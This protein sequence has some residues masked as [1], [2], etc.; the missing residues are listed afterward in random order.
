[1]APGKHAPAWPNMSQQLPNIVHFMAK[2]QR[3]QNLKPETSQTSHCC[4]TALPNGLW[5]AHRPPRH[6]RVRLPH[7]DTRTDI[8]QKVI[9]CGSVM[10]STGKRPQTKSKPNSRGRLCASLRS[11]NAHG[12]FA[13]A[14]LGPF[15]GN[16]QVK[17]REPRVSTLIKYRPWLLLWGK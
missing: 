14:I 8:S 6:F 1:M 7:K 2:S 4:N 10:K 13:R 3:N 9:L 17:G 15:C 16:L 11:R 12:H 5:A